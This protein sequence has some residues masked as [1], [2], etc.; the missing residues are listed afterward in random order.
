MVVEGRAELRSRMVSALGSRCDVKA[1]GD[2][3]AAEEALQRE[4]FHAAVIS[5]EIAG[6][7]PLALARRVAEHGC[8]VILVPDLPSHFNAAIR[9][10]HLIF[11]KFLRSE[12]L[13]ELVEKACA[14]GQTKPGAP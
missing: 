12:R 7:D 9:A 4:T 13:V 6:L 8:G 2:A 14:H 5:M 3:D 1:I 10:G 11:C